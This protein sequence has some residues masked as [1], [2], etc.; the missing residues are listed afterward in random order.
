M[1]TVF[2]SLTLKIIFKERAKALAVAVSGE[3]LPY[4]HLERFCAENGNGMILA[5]AS[6]VGMQPDTNQSPV[7][8]VLSF[9][10]HVIVGKKKLKLYIFQQ[11]C[12]LNVYAFFFAIYTRFVY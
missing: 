9:S 8:K 3:A 10:L 1:K 5:N 12:V 2:P 6:S 7:S 11:V 4:E